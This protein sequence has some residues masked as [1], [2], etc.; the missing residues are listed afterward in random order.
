[1]LFSNKNKNFKDL[2][3]TLIELMVTVSLTVLFTAF[4]ATSNRS[5]N[6]QIALYT[7]QGKIINLIYKAR[8][9]AI[10]TYTRTENSEDVPCGYGIYLNKIDYQSPVSEIII[11]KD[12]PDFDGTCKVYTDFINQQNLYNYDEG[13][14]FEVVK[15][16]NV[17]VN[18]NFTSMLFIPPDP[19]VYTDS[20]DFP[21]DIEI[22]SPKLDSSIYLQVNRFG[23]IVTKSIF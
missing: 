22:Y 15:L 7:E 21:L 9:L 6:N 3:F 16:S 11:F 19:V 10:S 18:A 13:E 5:T 8:S 23:Q 2:G 20:L 1:M 12:L 4:A 17:E 14:N